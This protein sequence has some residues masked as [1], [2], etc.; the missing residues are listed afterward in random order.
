MV[1]LS[2]ADIRAGMLAAGGAPV[3]KVVPSQQVVEVAGV[4]HTLEDEYQ[5]LRGKAWPKLVEDEDI[6]AHLEAENAYC[7]DFLASLGGL[8]EAFFQTMKGRMKLT[9]RTI[10]VRHGGY[11]YYS[12]TEEELQY[13]IDCRVPLAAFDALK[14]SGPVPDAALR[15]AEEVILDRNKL[16]EGKAFCK[17]L[18][19]TVSLNGKVMAYRVDTQGDENYCL[20]FVSLES[21]Y[22]PDQLWN[23]ASYCFHQPADAAETGA[24]PV[25]VFYSLRNR[26]LR[27]TKVFYHRLGDATDG[28]QDFAPNDR[29]LL[30][31]KNEM[32]G[33]SVGT[34]A[35]KEFV[36]VRHSSKTENEVLAIDVADGELRLVNLL[37][38]ADDVEYSV[39]KSGPHW[40]MRTKAGC[41]RDHFRLERGEWADGGRSEAL[42]HTAAFSGATDYSTNSVVVVL[43]TP[44]LPTTWYDWDWEA[45]GE[46]A[47]DAPR[48][49]PGHV[50]DKS[51]ALHETLHASDD[52]KYADSAVSVPVT[53]LYKK[54]LF[55]Q[56]GSMPLLLEGY[57]SYGISEEPAAKFLSKKR[58]FLDF[59]AVADKLADD[60][61]TSAGNVA[62]VGGSAGGMLVGACLNMRPALFKAIVAHVPFVTVLDTMLDGDLPLTPGEFKEW[63]N[64]REEHYFD[65]FPSLFA[66]AGLSD[67]RVGYYEAAKW[68]ARLRAGVAAAKAEAPDGAVNEPLLVFET[69][70]AAGHAG[71]SGRFDRLKEV[72]R[73]VAFLATEFDVQDVPGKLRRTSG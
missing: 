34:T 2:A 24:P 66:T 36:T 51:L 5:W 60:K 49:R 25:G 27:P 14:K 20:Q 55:R 12:R 68:V 59:I 13:S 52:P 58:T 38:M 42:S 43:D 15:G 33:V 22:L 6:I 23:V 48:T 56:D 61:F 3:A 7:K 57:G 19:T 72:S 46:P 35:D 47:C 30:E 29:L 41:Q 8:Q 64:P 26:N 44:S 69:N 17:A 32:F 45:R 50:H 39:S 54:S 40:F 63:G 71:A 67:Y 37:P 1:V 31:S 4:K 18:G 28:S 21:D 70:M 10:E 11:Y 62:I 9:D 16:A 53:V 73:D 65:V